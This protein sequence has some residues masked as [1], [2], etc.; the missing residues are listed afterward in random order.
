MA[1]HMNPIWPAVWAAT[2]AT[3]SFLT[4]VVVAVIQ[5]RNFRESF[6]PEIV[7]EGWR[8]EVGNNFDEI[9]FAT[10]RNIG[11]G[12]AFQVIL[13]VY[14][15]RARHFNSAFLSHQHR[16]VIAAQESLEIQGKVLLYW[17]QV[18]DYGGYKRLIAELPIHYLDYR[19]VEYETVYR[20][21][22]V[23]PPS[24]LGSEPIARGAP[25]VWSA[26]RSTTSRP[27]WWT[28][29]RVRTSQAWYKWWRNEARRARAARDGLM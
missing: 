18:P 15:G 10:V 11:R 25:G 5:W 19:G 17:N 2:A 27:L 13:G 22:V 3:F 8:R 24:Q 29:I 16:E 14:G 21:L 9:R 6:R 12:P 23:T 26:G 7:I 28:R 20:L 4:A 1:P